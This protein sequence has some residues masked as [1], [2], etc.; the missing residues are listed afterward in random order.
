MKLGLATEEVERAEIELAEQL[1]TLARRHLFESD[2]YHL[3]MARAK[4]CAEH[5]SQLDPLLAKY[6]ATAVEDA[7]KPDFLDNLGR[8][9]SLSGE[10][11][12]PTSLMLLRDLRDT[13]EV[14]HHTEISW[15][16]LQQAAKAGRDSE[17]LA[18]ALTGAEQTE[19]TWKWLRTKIKEATPE[20]LA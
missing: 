7:H 1:M 20:A 11:T 14:A 19:Q 10:R 3:G 9:I 15:I 5:L 13:Y 17:L 6:Q 4:V 8:D 2:V 16:M 12:A 18:V